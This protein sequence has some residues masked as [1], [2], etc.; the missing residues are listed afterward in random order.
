M[1]ETAPLYT[2]P[3]KIGENKVYDVCAKEPED[4]PALQISV[5]RQDSVHWV[6]ATKKFRVSKLTFQERT[7]EADGNC[8]VPE[9]PFYRNFPAD[10]VEFA[11]QINSGPARPK[12][13]GLI[14]KASFEFEDGTMYDPHIQIGK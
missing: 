7:Q 3:R 11:Y 8:E 9:Q 12:A 13:I 5:E 10:N 2:I 14:Y 6:S 4:H 1:G